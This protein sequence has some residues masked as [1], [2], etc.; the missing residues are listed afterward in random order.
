LC[1]N[2]LIRDRSDRGLASR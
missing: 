2:D 1:R